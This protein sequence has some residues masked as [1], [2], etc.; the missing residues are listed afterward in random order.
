MVRALCSLYLQETNITKPIHGRLWRAHGSSGATTP[1]AWELSQ[2]EVHPALSGACPIQCGC[3]CGLSVVGLPQAAICRSQNT[4]SD[5]ES[6]TH[7]ASFKG[8]IT[9]GEGAQVPLPVSFFPVIWIFPTLG[10]SEQGR[11][12]YL[13]QSTDPH[14]HRG[15]PKPGSPLTSS[16]FRSSP[17]PYSPGL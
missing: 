1:P 4:C 16:Q 9:D 14:S 8:K 12:L 17:W 3:E 15:V 13:K 6:A 2:M 11:E 10:L 5:M 7:R